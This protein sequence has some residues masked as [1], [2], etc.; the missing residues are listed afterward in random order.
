[1]AAP[2]YKKTPYRPD[3]YEN[4]AQQDSYWQQG[5]S[6]T[7]MMW[8][9][10]LGAEISPFDNNGRLKVKKD[11]ITGKMY[12]VIPHGAFNMQE[13][14]KKIAEIKGSGRIP[15]EAP[16]KMTRGKGT[17][18]KDRSNQFYDPS[19]KSTGTII[20]RGA[21]GRM[22]SSPNTQ[23]TN[24]SD[25]VGDNPN[26]GMAGTAY[27]GNSRVW[28]GNGTGVPLGTTGTG[29]R[30]SQDN[31]QYA[32]RPPSP[33]VYPQRPQRQNAGIPMNTGQGPTMGGY[34]KSWYDPEYYKDND[35]SLAFPNGQPNYWSMF[36]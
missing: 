30:T 2:D 31:A 27:Y 36:F 8:D 4:M 13:W 32:Y 25:Y 19:G 23:Q 35:Q 18:E 28:G 15:I 24:W 21:H 33:T 20:G 7:G 22:G 5:L 11:P 16:V 10:Q 3:W 9:T 29:I 1:M 14:D 12:E 34:E 6:G 17:S 26:K